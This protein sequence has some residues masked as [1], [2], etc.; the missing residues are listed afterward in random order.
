M[1]PPTDF[2]TEKDVTDAVRRW[3]MRLARILEADDKE[4]YIEEEEVLY[5][6]MVK[7]AV[8]FFFANQSDILNTR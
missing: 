2:A 6:H 7:F 4:G 5:A 3:E 8:F 1:P